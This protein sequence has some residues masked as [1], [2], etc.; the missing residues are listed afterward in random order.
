M[1]P[2]GQAHYYL[3]AGAFSSEALAKQLQN[4]L[5]RMT[6]SPVVIEHY[7]QHYI[8]RVGP[9]AAKNMTDNLKK[10]LVRNGVNGSFSVL[11]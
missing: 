11:I 4:K 8:V 1:G 9:F 5:A 10:Q 6:T 7:K 3:Q 2:A